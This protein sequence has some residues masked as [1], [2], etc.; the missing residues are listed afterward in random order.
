MTAN[1]VNLD[2]DPDDVYGDDEHPAAYNDPPP[3]ILTDDPD[4]TRYASWHLRKLAA[5]EDRKAE[6]VRAFDK[7]IEHLE[8]RRDRAL[9]HIEHKLAWHRRPLAQAHEQILEQDP[10]RKTIQLPNGKLTSRTPSKPIVQWQDKDEFT[11]W[12]AKTNRKLVEER[13]V[14]TQD[15]VRAAI[16]SGL[17]VPSHTP[18]PGEPAHLIVVLTGERVP[19]VRYCLGDTTFRPV[20]DGEDWDL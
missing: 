16:E 15:L 14:A 9:A 8:D 2:I 6:L 17:L 18:T 20:V 7:E 11:K 13:L 12:A 3:F 10:K 4:W 19:G 1:L 5:W